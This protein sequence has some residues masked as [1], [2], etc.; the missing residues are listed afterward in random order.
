MKLGTISNFLLIVFV[1]QTSNENRVLIS[2]AVARYFFV[3]VCKNHI[4]ICKHK[5]SIGIS[6]FKQ[7]IRKSYEEKKEAD[8]RNMKDVNGL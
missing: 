2:F 5:L 7:C 8:G 6:K 3:F 1:T 4:F